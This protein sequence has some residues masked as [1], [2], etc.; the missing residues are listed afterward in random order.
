MAAFSDILHYLLEA[1]MTSLVQ[2]LVLPGPLILLAFF[3]HHISRQVERYSVRLMGVR[4]YLI[5]FGWLGTAM[6]EIGHAIFCL[7]FGHR[8]TGMKLFSPDKHAGSMGYV[9][10]SFNPKNLYHQIGNFFI[11]IG[12]IILGSV[13]LYAMVWIHTGT[14]ITQMIQ[15]GNMPENFESLRDIFIV[16]HHIWIVLTDLLPVLLDALSKQW[17]KALIVLYVLFSAGSALALSKSDI[18]SAASGL[19]YIFVLFLIFNLIFLWAG[20][21]T[22]MLVT[23]IAT[24]LSGIFLLM[25][26]SVIINGVF[27]LILFVLTRLIAR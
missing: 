11:G 16:F 20:D 8:I 22:G 23:Q 3:S 5:A 24:F 7:L 2:L 14:R 18:A 21:F 15:I 6:H 1:L 26:M 17:W 10:H 27:L 12:P 19:K 25:L 4:G 13:L 9:H